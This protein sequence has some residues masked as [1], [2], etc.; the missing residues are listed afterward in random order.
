MSNSNKTLKTS[1]IQIFI[2]LDHAKIRLEVNKWNSYLPKYF[3]A[4]I[5]IYEK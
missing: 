3:R 4:A 1:W 5:V 2:K